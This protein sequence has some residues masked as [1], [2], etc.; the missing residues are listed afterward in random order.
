MTASGDGDPT[1]DRRT[2]AG[3]IGEPRWPMALAA[4][5]TGAL[6]AALYPQLR[7]LPPELLGDS[8]WAYLVGVAILL[9]ILIIG[10]PGRID[11]GARWLRV[12]TVTMIAL[13]SAD[14]IV[15]SIRLVSAIM[16]T[17]PFTEDANTLL[18]SGSA[19]WLTNVI[20]FA[21]WYWVMDRGGPVG[22]AR[23]PMVMPAFAFPEMV[24]P[25]LVEDGW[26][27]RF[28]DYLHLSFSTATSF[29]PSDVSGIKPWAKLTMMLEE[30]I[31]LVIAILVVARAVNVLK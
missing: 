24:N 13:I 11:R 7:S 22:R 21:L 31:S 12:V 6:H 29:S 16:R 26:Y 20:A 8:R 15:V 3:D 23:G 10:D 14:T 25:Q 2:R 1:T 4:L 18:I 17:L 19:I 5:A 9:G 30:S 28:V 27:P